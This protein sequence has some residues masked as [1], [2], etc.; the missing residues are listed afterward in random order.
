MD[1]QRLTTF[2]LWCTII[3]GG[4]L[5]L[6]IIGVDFPLIWGF[7]TFLL[8]FIPNIGSPAETNG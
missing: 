5:I 4:L 6:S 8:N 2:F 3:N 7:L 1:I